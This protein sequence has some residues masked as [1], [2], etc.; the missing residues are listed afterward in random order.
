MGGEY[1][2]PEYERIVVAAESETECQEQNSEAMVR[3]KVD[4]MARLALGEGI[5]G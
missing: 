1:R 2:S 5:V 4:G 3:A